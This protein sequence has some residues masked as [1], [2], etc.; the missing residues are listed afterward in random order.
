MDFGYT[1]VSTPRQNIER[2]VRNIQRVS[3]DATIL[4][5]IY[6]GTKKDGRKEW[7][8]LLKMLRPG[9]TVY[10]DSVSRMSRNADEGFEDYMMLME[11]GIELV[12]LNE[13]HINTQTFK[14]VKEQSVPLT[15]TL[16]DPILEG[17]NKVLE[18]M[19]REN[20]RLAFEQ[21]ETEVMDL[22]KRTKGGMETA[23]RNGKQIGGKKGSTYVTAK[24][25][26]AKQEIQ[27]YSKTF[28]GPLKDVECIRL[29]GIAENTYYK[30]KREL[31]AEL[32]GDG[33][34]NPSEPSEVPIDSAIP[35]RV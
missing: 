24:S 34:S 19:A 1:R 21:S 22:R 23:R 31:I 10:F 17:V 30:Y 2:Q 16:I 13:P 26:A 9:D 20:I 32:Y 33:S 5:E 12:F 6:T 7:A 18:V 27:K 29:I 35:E 3:P 15:G 14:R 25:K 28:G 4:K 11:Q 8:K